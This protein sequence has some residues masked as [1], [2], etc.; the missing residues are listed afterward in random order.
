MTENIF[1]PY[2]G[3]YCKFTLRNGNT[4]TGVL[5]SFL[6]DMRA[7]QF[8]PSIKM[9]EYQPYMDRGDFESM[10]PLCSDIEIDDII[11]AV[12]LR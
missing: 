4:I 6:G 9:I 10:R 3:K 2:E 8:V 11:L 7:Y 12:Q 1:S 5:S